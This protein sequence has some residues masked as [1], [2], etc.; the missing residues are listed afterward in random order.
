MK[1][2]SFYYLLFITLVSCG[3]IIVSL[4]AQHVVGLRP[5]IL[6]FYERYAY[7]AMGI[8]ALG[9][10]Y[11]ASWL[12]FLR[13]IILGTILVGAGISFYHVGIEQHWWV[14]FSK[15]NIQPVPVGATM[16]EIRA[17]IMNSVR[18]D[19]AQFKIFGMTAAF[20]NFVVFL[21]LFVAGG[22]FLICSR[23]VSK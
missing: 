8:L 20:W 18:C 4:F 7:I 9:A 22:K 21:C 10:L 2:K 5:C 19:E 1:T 12:P 13:W 15:C 16:E 17:H 6:C 14:G 11:L 23:Y 3:A